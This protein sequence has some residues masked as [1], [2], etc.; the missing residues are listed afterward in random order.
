L[1]TES[2]LEVSGLD[3]KISSA[4]KSG[5]LL[6]L[7][8]GCITLLFTVFY[9]NYLTAKLR[10]NQIVNINLYVKAVNELAKDNV[11]DCSMDMELAVAESFSLPVILEDESGFL[12]S[13]YYEDEQH[14]D[15]MFLE[16]KKEDFLRSGKEPII[17]LGYASKVYYFDPPLT[18]Y[19]KLFPPFQF[20]LIAIFILLGYFLINA[21]RQAEQ[22]LL[23]AGMAKET[24]HQL[25]TPISAIMGWIEVLKEKSGNDNEQEE[26]VTELIKDADRLALIAD[27]FSKIGSTPVLEETNLYDEVLDVKEYMQVR[28][29]RKVIFEII[30]P[31][32]P[33][34]AMINRHLFDWVIEN[35][36]RNSLDAMSGQGKIMVD[37]EADH[38]YLYINV[39]DTG[40]GI[41]QKKIKEVFKPGYSTKKRGWGL[42]L[43]LAKR[44][45]EDYHTGK[46]YVK[47]SKPN[48]RTT[49]T[50]RLSKSE[51][52]MSKIA[53]TH[54]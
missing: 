1:Y 52:D 36:M 15:D 30:E 3:M 6:L 33:V 51:I 38:K 37:F 16:K 47:F 27:R 41:P 5:K 20:V 46:I 17:G 40:S 13:S 45:I 48:E 4:N 49:F 21:S 54:K 35:L 18:T 43:S 9:A 28:S 10:E 25:G 24:A 44:I 11:S 29:S 31:Q 32:V 39:S 42:G 50:I 2:L 8:V 22:N 34:M 14:A 7:L 26:I 19:I 23:W 12:S 53:F